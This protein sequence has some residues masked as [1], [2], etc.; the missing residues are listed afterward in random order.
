MV[1]DLST[2][3]EDPKVGGG[4]LACGSDHD[5]SDVGYPKRC[6]PGVGLAS[7][8]QQLARIESVGLNF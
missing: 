4:T 6:C 1:L 7:K 2:V 3:V 8:G 5:G